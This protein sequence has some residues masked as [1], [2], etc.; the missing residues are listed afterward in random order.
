MNHQ[1]DSEPLNSNEFRVLLTLAEGEKNSTEIRGGLKHDA[2][3]TADFDDN[4]LYYLTR[5]LSSRKYIRQSGNRY[6]LEAA[7]VER[8][9]LEA[10]RWDYWSKLVRERLP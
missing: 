1:V 4:R 7:G 2:L 8:L 9:K 6:Q 10:A 3:T 5:K